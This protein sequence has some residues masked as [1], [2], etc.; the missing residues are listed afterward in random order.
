[1]VALAAAAVTI[2][3]AL[4][5]LAVTAEDVVGRNGLATHDTHVL[6][7]FVHHRNVWLIRLSRGLTDL[8]AVGVL[9]V[10]AVAAAVLLWLAG[11]RLA[12]AIAPAAALGIAGALAGVGK[13]LVA[14]SRPGM[15]LHLVKETNGSF[16]SGHATDSTAFLVALALVLAVVVLHSARLRALIVAG[17][18]LLAAAIGMSRLE[19][20]VHW[21]TD[22]LAGYALGL[23][24]AVAVTTGAVLASRTSSPPPP[25]AQGKWRHRLSALLRSQ[26]PHSSLL[27]TAAA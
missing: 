24:V 18:G 15:D 17:A 7:F 27:H 26:R 12:M 8:G 11:A 9:A 6:G 5:V 4:A 21:P 10:L 16:P 1:M 14:R 3:G 25:D 19:L 20:G 22:I 23:A 2:F 13:L